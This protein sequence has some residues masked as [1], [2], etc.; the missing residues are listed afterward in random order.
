MN[1]NITYYFDLVGTLTEYRTDVPIEEMFEPGYYERLASHN[2]MVKVLEDMTREGYNVRVIASYYEKGDGKAEMTAWLKNHR[3]GNVPVVFVPY[4][5]DKTDFVEPGGL[6]V[7]VDD[8]TYELTNWR[9]AGYLAFKY[10]NGINGTKGT[11]KGYSVDRR[12]SADKIRTAIT[13]IA[14]AEYKRRTK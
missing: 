6:A 1:R 2:G 7:L 8:Y 3:L 12:M 9:K 11:W 5:K 14:E 13:A 4:G 10:Y